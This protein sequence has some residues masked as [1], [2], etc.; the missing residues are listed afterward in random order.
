MEGL[1]T[2]GGLVIG[3]VIAVLIAQDANARG[4]NGLGWGIFV[5][6]LCIVA[7]PVYLVVRSPRQDEG[8][9]E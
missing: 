8:T 1:F 5:F 3:A 2:V 7:L 9:S 6:L 4:M